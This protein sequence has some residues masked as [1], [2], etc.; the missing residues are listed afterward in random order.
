MSG[1]GY[2]QRMFME[3]AKFLD[4]GVEAGFQKAADLFMSALVTEF[5]FGETK[6]MRLKETV[7]RLD[8]EY[9]KA[10]LNETESGWAQ[11]QIDAV[12]KHVSGDQFVPFRQR[13]QY[14]QQFNYNGRCKR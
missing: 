5:G 1:K 4:I 3:R 13:N 8:K 2:A 12:L 14:I 10:W 9:G 6:V 7:E 11:E